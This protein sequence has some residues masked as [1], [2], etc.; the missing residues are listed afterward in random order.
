[1]ATQMGRG[2]GGLWKARKTM[3]RVFR[4]SHKP[5]K[6]RAECIGKMKIVRSDFHIPSAPAA[7]M[8][9]FQNP[10]GQ[11]PISPTLRFLQAHPSIGKD[12]E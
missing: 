3:V 6:S 9:Q 5:W 12:S 11:N 10:K 4:P 7:S 8:N 1:M 2:N